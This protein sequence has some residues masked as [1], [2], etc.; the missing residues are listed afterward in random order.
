MRIKKLRLQRGWSQDQLSQLSGLSVRTIQRIESGQK[1]GL[2]S[3]K[4]LA[5]VFETTVSNLQGE[6]DMT[7]SDNQTHKVDIEERLA[8]ARVKRIKG[9]YKHLIQYAVVIPVLFTIN[10]MTNPDY[11]WAFWPL[12]G[13]GL[14]LMFHGLTTFE[15]IK[16]FGPSWEKRQV[17]KYLGRKL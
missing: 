2:E 11:I 15:L 9:F 8:F 4:A 12:L 1:A 5:A 7:T 17:E 3:L 10:L 14:G 13:W 16:L 6:S